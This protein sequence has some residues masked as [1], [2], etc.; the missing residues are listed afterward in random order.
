MKF[1]NTN[2]NSQK[3]KKYTSIRDILMI[4]PILIALVTAIILAIKVFHVKLF[5]D[6]Y[7]NFNNNFLGIGVGVLI[8][9]VGIIIAVIIRFTAFSKKIKSTKDSETV[10][11]S[12]NIAICDCCG[13]YFNFSE[14]SYSL[15][16]SVSAVTRS[17]ETSSTTTYK[18]SISV[19]ETCPKCKTHGGASIQVNLGEDSTVTK[20]IIFTDND[21]IISSSHRN[22]IDLDKTVKNVY[23][24]HKSQ[25]KRIIK[26]Y[27][28]KNYVPDYLIK[29]KSKTSSHDEPYSKSY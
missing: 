25:A 22:S 20:H 9:F 19:N 27:S 10:D 16:N 12:S 17:G 6:N 29:S 28:N 15:N 18:G 2:A 23:D 24:N 5:Q 4:L 14:L 11:F 21:K 8:V 1:I 26:D 13:R 7:D 3:L